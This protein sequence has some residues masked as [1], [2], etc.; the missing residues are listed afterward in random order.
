M[1]LFNNEI[2][3]YVSLHMNMSSIKSPNVN[4]KMVSERFCFQ[5]VRKQVVFGAR[6]QVYLCNRSTQNLL[7]EVRLTGHCLMGQSNKLF[8]EY[9]YNFKEGNSVN[10]NSLMPPF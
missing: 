9:E 1:I 7:G 5:Y 6:C 10:V 2:M 8:K 4:I 3:K